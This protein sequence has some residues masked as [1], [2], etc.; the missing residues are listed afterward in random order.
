[1]K[2][3]AR[4]SF[5]VQAE[6]IADLRAGDENGDAVGKANDDRARKIFD[7]GAHAGD[8]EKDQEDASH[9]GAEEQALYAMFCDDAGDD[10]N[11]GTG[12]ATDLRFGPAK[13]G[14]YESSDDS[15][16]ETVLW[17][18]AGGDREGH[19]ERESYEADG[20][21]GGEVREKFL[22]VVVAEKDYGFG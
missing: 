10:D 22:A 3:I 19:G 15:A 21:A 11:E 20:D 8:A 5:N 14:N 18:N 6:K 9:H 1:M 16:V 7:G 4:E 2:E 17:R 12:G 13:R